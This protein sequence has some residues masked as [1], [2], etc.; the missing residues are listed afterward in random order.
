MADLL[1]AGA[2]SVAMEV[3]SHALHQ[4]RVNSVPFHTAVFT[5]LSRD[6]LDYHGS[7]EA[8]AEAKS[9]LFRQPGLELAVV[10]TDDALG[11]QLAQ[12]LKG[13]TRLVA[14][15]RAHDTS[16][17][18]DEYIQITGSGVAPR[19]LRISLD[20]SWGKGEIHSRLVGGF[21]AG[22]LVLVLG[23]LLGWDILLD[24]ALQRLQQVY[25]VAGRMQCIGAGEQPLVVVDYAHTPDALEQ[26]LRAARE[27]VSGRLICVFGCGGDRDKGKRPL[28]GALAEQLADEVIITDDNRRHESSDAIIGH[29]MEGIRDQRALR[30]IPERA[31]AIKTA[32]QIASAGDL[33]K[34][35]GKG[36]ENYQQVRDLKHP[37]DDAAEVEPT[38]RGLKQG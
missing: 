26:A 30:V 16:A 23:V 4:Q 18:A 1:Q 33:V 3:S 11:W 5:N 13:K 32:V 28:M 8:Y 37:F 10:N 14:C 9:R 34:V 27:H 31:R 12:E 17:R 7:M 21:N 19:G 6:H 24:E 20:S 2:R 35:P 36:H 22:N 38:L 25:P 29:I 15:G